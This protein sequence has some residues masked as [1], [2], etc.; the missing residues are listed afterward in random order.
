[1]S[2]PRVEEPGVTAWFSVESLIAASRLSVRYLRTSCHWQRGHRSARY[3]RHGRG[4]TSS[5]RRC[6]RLRTRAFGASG[7]RASTSMPFPRL[8]PTLRRTLDVGSAQSTR[9]RTGNSSVVDL[10]GGLNVPGCRLSRT[11]CRD[12]AILSRRTPG[13]A[14]SAGSSFACV[15]SPSPASTAIASGG[16]MTAGPG[17]RARLL[18]CAIT[19]I[20]RKLRR[21]DV[22]DRHRHQGVASVAAMGKAESVLLAQSS[23]NSQPSAGGTAGRRARMIGNIIAIAGRRVGRGGD[24]RPAVSSLICALLLGPGSGPLMVGRRR[25]RRQVA[26]EPRA[27]SDAQPSVPA[28]SPGFRW[29]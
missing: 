11:S 4:P 5:T 18:R 17:S 15:C 20:L 19:A 6:R 2:A 23:I 12:G 29:D 8:R 27:G 22:G 7:S 10:Q 25:R 9:P 1:M 21:V 3:W 26:P 28:S 24:C 14:P 13:R 16:T